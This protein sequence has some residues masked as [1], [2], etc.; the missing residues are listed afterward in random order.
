[1]GRRP[2]YPETIGFLGDT[3]CGSY[4]GLHPTGED[5]LPKAAKWSGVRYLMSC[6]AHLL[7][8]WPRLDVLFLTGDLIDGPQ[9]K[10]R[11]TNLFTAKLSEQ[12]DL[13]IE[14]L[15]PLVE[16]ATQTLRVDGTPYHEEYH[17]A[18]RQLDAELG[19]ARAQQV[20]DLE[21]E[22]GILNVAHHPTGGAVLYRGTQ[23]DREALWST[24]AAARRKVPAARWIFRAHQHDFLYQEGQDGA[25]CSLPCWELQT[26][27]AKKLA[28]WRFQPSLGGVLL[29]RDPTHHLG[30][31]VEATLYDPP[32]PSVLRLGDL[33]RASA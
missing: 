28:Y 13:A 31:R 5:W 6:Y 18:L 19:V 3:H 26:P 24:I 27:H 23:V 29:R 9:S 11:A 16:K 15:R 2:K 17:G 25:V 7:E 14:V 8:K 1:M 20:I 33:R 12:T 4:F 21:L 30:Y 10:A 22:G 32:L